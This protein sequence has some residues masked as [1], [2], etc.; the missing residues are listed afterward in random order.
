VY[1]LTKKC[2]IQEPP[3]LKKRCHVADA[4]VLNRSTAIIFT[5][6]ATTISLCKYS[7]ESVSINHMENHIYL[8]RI[9]ENVNSVMADYLE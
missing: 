8:V 1:D 4:E 7:C 3:F 2:K 6:N 5:A 9:H